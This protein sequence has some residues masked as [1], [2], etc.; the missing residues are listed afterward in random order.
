MSSMEQP[1]ELGKVVGT[2]QMRQ[3]EREESSDWSAVGNL[4]GEVTTSPVHFQ[5]PSCI[6]G[7][8]STSHLQFKNEIYLGSVLTEINLEEHVGA[9]AISWAS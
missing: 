2:V 9:L 8:S 6:C 7:T 4:G 3:A 5:T 1:C